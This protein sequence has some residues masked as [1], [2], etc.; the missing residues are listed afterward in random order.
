MTT[1]M[2][3]GLIYNEPTPPLEFNPTLMFYSFVNINTMNRK[4]PDTKKVVAPVVHHF[5]D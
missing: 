1:T 5:T 4:P 2:P 3:I